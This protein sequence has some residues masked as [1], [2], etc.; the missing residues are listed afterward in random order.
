V[1]LQVAL[2]AVGQE[3]AYAQLMAQTGAAFSLRVA[4]GFGAELAHEGREA[5]VAPALAELGR[6][7]HLMTEPEPGP[8]FDVCRAQVMVGR[9]VVVRG[10]GSNP[11][12]WAV[13]VGAQGADLLGYCF[14]AVARRERHPATLSAALVLGDKAVPLLAAQADGAALSRALALLTE[15]VAQYAAWL[16]LLETPEPYGP[17]LRRAQTFLGEQW[18]SACLADARE[19]AADYLQS[20]AEL[21]PEALAEV[22]FPA[23]DCAGRLAEETE[24]LLVPPDAIH[25]S[26]L[27]EDLDWR[28]RRRETVSTLRTLEASL[29]DHLRRALRVG[30]GNPPRADE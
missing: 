24:R 6:D 30:E 11:A 7:A 5:S 13:I 29:A 3:T 16:D 26:H 12:E 2:R 14:G 28:Q 18:L 10:W 4:A 20:L 1:C 8:A 17:P 25:R 27:P 9:P 15:N 22:L 23:T 21:A 19:A